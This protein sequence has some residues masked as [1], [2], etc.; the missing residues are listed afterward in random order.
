VF[1]LQYVHNS[2][3]H[4]PRATGF[5]EAG[6][7]NKIALSTA[8]AALMLGLGATGAFADDCSGRDHSTGTVLGAAG[9][10]IIGG[11]ASHGN[12][13]GIIGGAPVGGLAGNAISRDTDCNDQQH[14]AQSYVP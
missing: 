2:E 12:G 6:M 7:L 11:V 4:I 5:K 9:G 13:L 1:T 10:G 14:A 3:R 8:A